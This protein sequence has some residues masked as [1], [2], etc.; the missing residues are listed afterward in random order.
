[1]CAQEN[2]RGDSAVRVKWLIRTSRVVSAG[3]R[4][5]QSGV[6]QWHHVGVVRAFGLCQWGKSISILGLRD[7]ILC[8]Q[9]ELVQNIL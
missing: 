7:E 1:M 6:T 5:W 3:E 2:T 9:K 4:R 8:H